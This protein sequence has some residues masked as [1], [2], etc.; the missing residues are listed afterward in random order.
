[1][2]IIHVIYFWSATPGRCTKALMPPIALSNI[3]VIY[4]LSVTPGRCIQPITR[5]IIHVIYLLS[6]TPG[7]CSHAINSTYHVHYPCYLFLERYTWAMYES[8]NATYRIV[9]YPCYLFN[10]RYTWA[11]YSTYHTVYY[12]CYLFIERLHLGDVC[13]LSHGLL[14]MLSIY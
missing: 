1:M 11:M 5:S 6:A 12:P 3:H 9:Q 10:E 4:L 14:S 8:I 13:N 7:R 2:S